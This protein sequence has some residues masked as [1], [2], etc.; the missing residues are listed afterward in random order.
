MTN[1]QKQS[2]GAILYQGP[3]E[4]DGAPIVVIAV[5]LQNSSKNRKT[6][7]MIQ[8]YILRADLTPMEAIWTGQDAS[9][10]GTCPH[11]G[12]GTGKGRSCYVNVAQ[13]VTVVSKQYRAGRYPTLT[14]WS[15]FSGRMVRFGTYGDPAAV[16]LEVWNRIAQQQPTG[17]TGYTHQWR[18]VG[19]TGLERYCMASADTEQDREDAVTMGYRTFRVRAANERRMKGE[20]VCPA[21]EEAGKKLQCA[22]CGACDGLRR[23]ARGGITIVVHGTKGHTNAFRRNVAA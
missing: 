7:G 5:G 19:A 8:T 13:G 23:K 3:S 20:A 1:Q 18:D 11:R 14:D 10:C 12:D 9:I 4:L 21:S 16:P 17:W 2:N 15:V 22:D 6:G